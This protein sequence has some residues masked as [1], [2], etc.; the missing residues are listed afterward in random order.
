MSANLRL[1]F[2]YFNSSPTE[3]GYVDAFNPKVC[4][5]SV[6]LSNSPLPSSL[7]LSPSLSPHIL[8]EWMVNPTVLSAPPHPHPSYLTPSPFPHHH[9]PCLFTHSPP[10]HPLSPFFSPFFL[11]TPSLFPSF[12]PLNPHS[13]SPSSP[14]SC[15]ITPSPSHPHH[16][17]SLLTP[18][19]TYPPS[20]A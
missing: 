7:P 8:Q 12:F 4:T 6:S 20:F 2:T 19:T 1:F 9:P 10:H 11:L 5:Q 17:S 16:P 14:T 13:L 18:T 15:L 3:I